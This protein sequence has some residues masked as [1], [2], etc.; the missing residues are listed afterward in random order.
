MPLEIHRGGLRQ[1]THTKARRNSRAKRSANRVEGGLRGDLN[2][3][4]GPLQSNDALAAL[5]SPWP[6]ALD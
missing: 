5:D 4:G 6:I 3:Q 1:S 2:A